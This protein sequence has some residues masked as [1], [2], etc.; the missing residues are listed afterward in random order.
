[1]QR[2]VLMA[3][4]GKESDLLEMEKIRAE[5]L[6]RSGNPQE[7]LP[8]FIELMKNEPVDPHLCTRSFHWQS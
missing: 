1:M 2:H 3:Q 6:A 4:G 8:V 5:V 7:A